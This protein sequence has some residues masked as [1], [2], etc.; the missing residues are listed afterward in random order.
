MFMKK[1]LLIAAGII[2]AI[3]LFY[4]TFNACNTKDELQNSKK[5]KQSF[6]IC[7]NISY[8]DT[9]TYYSRDRIDP[10]YTYKVRVTKDAYDTVYLWV[11]H[12]AYQTGH[13]PICIFLVDATL[14][15][16]DDYDTLYFTMAQYQNYWELRFGAENMINQNGSGN[17]GGIQYGCVCTEGTGGCWWDFSTGNPQ[18][19]KTSPSTCP[20]CYPQETGGSGGSGSSFIVIQADNIKYNGSIYD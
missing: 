18:C 11:D 3:S 17:G 7:Q 8:G 15:T 2:T 13:L 12:I 19:K 4:V 9:L 1:I 16:T 14:Y 5:P 6:S 10:D 20:T